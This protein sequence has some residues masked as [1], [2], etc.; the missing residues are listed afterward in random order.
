MQG[1]QSLGI[2]GLGGRQVLHEIAKMY[3]YQLYMST[4]NDVSSG[5]LA[6]LTMLLNASPHLMVTGF[7]KVIFCFYDS[8][9]QIENQKTEFLHSQAVRRFKAGK[10]LK[11]IKLF[12]NYG[13]VIS[14]MNE[15]NF[16]AE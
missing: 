12:S 16:V 3:C 4:P 9:F 13:T 11:I 15:I 8:I 5:L 2:R 14:Y 10:L 6:L 1:L 7:Q